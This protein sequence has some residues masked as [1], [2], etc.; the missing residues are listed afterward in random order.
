MRD[1]QGRVI[2]AVRDFIQVKLTGQNVGQLAQRQLEYDT[3]FSLHQGDYR[4]K[5]LVRE[6]ETGKMGTFETGFNIPDLT[7]EKSYLRLSSVI[8]SNQ[9]EPL[10][11]AV[12]AAERN[13]KAFKGHP[14]VKENHKLIP[15]ITRVFRPEQNLFVYVE[16]Y[17]ARAAGE[18]TPGEIAAT[19]SLFRGKVKEFES[20][21]LRV[22]EVQKD[23]GGAFSVEIQLPLA[24]LEPGSYTCQVNVLDPGRRKFAFRRAPLILLP[25]S[26]GGT[27]G[28]VT[29][30]T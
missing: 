1:K 22:T 21:P 24:K 6:N 17:D 16:V 26:G 29:F 14:L 11:A 19:V 9:R 10:S 20:E 18:T 12:G 5:F 28:S 7:Q 3:A 23:K 27:Y 30:R 8:W 2:S 25:P 4:V 13:R 15:S